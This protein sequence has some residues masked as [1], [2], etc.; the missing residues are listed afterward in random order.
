VIQAGCQQ[1]GEESA[2]LHSRVP[3][4]Q[5]INGMPNPEEFRDTNFPVLAHVST[6]GLSRRTG[7]SLAYCGLIKRGFVVPHQMRREAMA[8]R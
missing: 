3:E 8:K 5:R 1:L 6:R 4:W 7:L 2:D